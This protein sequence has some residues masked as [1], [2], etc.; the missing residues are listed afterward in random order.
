MSKTPQ[1]LDYLMQQWPY[2]FGEV[3][4]RV[5]AGADGRSVLQ[6]RVDMG[7]LQMETTGRP[8]GSRPGGCETYYDH[9]LSLAFQEGESFELDAERCLEV[10]REFLQFFHRRIC[11]LALR[12][13]E[14]AAADAAHTLALMDFS[15]AH[16][17]CQ[18]WAEMHEQFRS[19][20][21]FHRIQAAALAQL[22]HDK[23][24]AAL[25][26]LDAGLDE[27]RKV[28]AEQLSE[29]F[30][31]FEDFDD[32]DL[33]L[34]LREMKDAITEHYKVRPPLAEQ[35]ANAVA[36]EKY[37]LAARLRDKIAHQHRPRI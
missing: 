18:E 29:D 11:W 34:K 1:H 30:D 2:E 23:A 27:L 21:L 14:R 5:V 22:E 16:A 3:S 24:R 13:F 19:F 9:L 33:V 8:D 12:E 37:E 35:L 17:P 36:S 15:T 20:V 7:V 32:D 6:L 26:V 28:Y 4:A 10:E 25:E 31:E